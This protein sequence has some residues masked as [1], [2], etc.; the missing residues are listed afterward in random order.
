MYFTYVREYLMKSFRSGS[1]NWN[2]G[3]DTVVPNTCRPV[4]VAIHFCS[5]W[6]ATGF[7]RLCVGVLSFAS[8][9]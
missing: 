6:F 5:P 3:H 7:G 1:S 8:F 4:D 2:F 9:M